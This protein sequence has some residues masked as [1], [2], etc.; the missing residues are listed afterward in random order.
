MKRVMFNAVP[1]IIRGRGLPNG[2]T[3]T[4]QLID[5]KPGF[6]NASRL[7]HFNIDIDKGR[8]YVIAPTVEF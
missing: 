4:I 5:F 8:V 6:L 7:Q 1:V 3:Q 2:Q